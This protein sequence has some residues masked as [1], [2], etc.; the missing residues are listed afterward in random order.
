MRTRTPL[1]TPAGQGQAGFSMLE[2]LMAAFIMAIGIMGISM[3]QLM[4]L[5]SSRGSR[6]LTTAVQV[7]EQFLD[8]VETEG[9]LTWLNITDTPMTTPPTLPTMQFI[10]QAAPVVRTFTIKGRTPDPA[11]TDPAD[12]QPFFTAT[13][14]RSAAVATSA[15]GQTI[16]DYT[17]TVVFGDTVQAGS[18]TAII[19]RNVVLTRRILHG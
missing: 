12:L 8:A 5:R 18:T 17:V 19:Q 15:T 1:S 11:A 2:M 10:S 14:R 4:S 7:A 9:R 3:L 16:H 6:S 13:L